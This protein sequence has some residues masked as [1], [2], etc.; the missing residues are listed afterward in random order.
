MTVTIGRLG[1]A[2]L[3]ATTNT[4]VYTVPAGRQSTVTVAVSNRSANTRAVRVA[5]LPSATIGSLANAD[6]LLY[7]FPLGPGGYFRESGLPVGAGHSIVARADGADIT[8]Q[9]VGVEEVI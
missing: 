8:V 1:A 9:V 5:Y 2:D 4:I 7:D 6:W 3:A